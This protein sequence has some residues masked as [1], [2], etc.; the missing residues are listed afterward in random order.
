MKVC[1]L[2]PDYS[3]SSVDYRNYDPTRDLSGL[4]PEHTVHHEALDKRTTYAQLKRLSRQGFDIYVN[5]C[6]GYLEW[7]VP[8]VDVI[9]SLELSARGSLEVA[10]GSDASGRYAYGDAAADLGGIDIG[11]G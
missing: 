9:E 10:A 4:L 11:I 6:E 5:L 8:S 7:D 2:Q 3:A 1:V